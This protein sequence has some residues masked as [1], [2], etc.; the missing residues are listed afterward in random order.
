MNFINHSWTVFEFLYYLSA[1]VLVILG[2]VGLVNL[3]QAKEEFRQVKKEFNYRVKKESIQRA[4]EL[5]QYYVKEIIPSLSEFTLIFSGS[6]YEA[7]INKFDQHKFNNFDLLELREII[8]DNH[9]E[10]SYEAVTLKIS[11]S[12][13]EI[14]NRKVE[15]KDKNGDINVLTN[16]FRLEDLMNNLEYFSMNFVTG[17]ADKETVYRAIHQT[18]FATIKRLYFQIAR[19]NEQPKDKF[20]NNIIEL[21]KE[22]TYKDGEITKACKQ[23]DID[24]TEASRAFSHKGSSLPV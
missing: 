9:K 23:E 22:W 2:S 16:R 10:G 4:I 1:P 6:Q 3:Y 15:L 19:L 7:E 18:Y 5:T 21:Y 20:Y 12:L 14:L 11:N 17:I 13:E 8:M 24:H